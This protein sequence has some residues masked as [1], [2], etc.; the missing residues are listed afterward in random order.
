MRL[1]SQ[2]LSTFGVIAAICFAVTVAAIVVMGK[3]KAE[4]Q[5][6]ESEDFGAYRSLTQAESQLA[7]QHAQLYRTMT[8]IGSMKDDEVK[9]VRDELAKKMAEIRASIGRIGGG[10]VDA[11]LDKYTKAA[12]TAVDLASVDPNT[13]VAA[14]QTADGEFRQLAQQVAQQLEAIRQK[15]QTGFADSAALANRSSWSFGV[16]A[17][18][19]LAISAAALVMVLRRLVGSLDDAKR[20]AAAVASGDLQADVG[21]VGNDEVGELK[22]SLQDMMAQLRATVGQVRTASENIHTASAEIATGNQD[23][24][25]RTEQQASSLQETA[26]SMEQLTGTVKQNAS[27]AEQANQLASGASEVAERGGQVV[28]QVVQ[29][30][31][32]IT[33]ASRKI[34]EIITV[35]DGIAFQTNIL[36]LNAAVEAAR[37]GEQGRGFAVVAGEVRNL[38]QRSA[39]AAREIKTLISASLEQVESGSRQ[40][41]EAG[42]TMDEIVAQVKR[43]SSLIG[44][45]THATLEQSSGIGQVNQAVTQLDQVTQQNAALVEQ[46]AAAA[47]SLK[48]QAGR[49]A[50]AVSI[51]KLGQQTIAKAQASSR[52]AVQEE[53]AV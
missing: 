7:L 37:A 17:V 44:E 35:V 40:V 3:L 12:D 21:Q 29:T 23:L 19:A 31:E 11:L 25:S 8:I 33:Q 13:G 5:R 24:S 47:E 6:V 1:R 41:G 2:L 9:R 36:A 52:A 34:A 43:V 49:L 14:M 10:G 32:G 50:E 45:I 16:L 30:M 53:A 27:A 46:S 18:L 51:F 26:A 4:M 20:V 48:E 28:G 38:A 39:Q 42:R 22:H 15:V